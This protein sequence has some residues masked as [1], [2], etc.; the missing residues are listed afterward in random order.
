MTPDELYELNTRFEGADPAALIAWAADQFMPRMA[1]TSSFQ[2][3]S[4]ALLHLISLS[5]GSCFFW[6]SRDT[7]LPQH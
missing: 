7:L 1:A 4:V 5:Y 2:T 6:N 3:Q